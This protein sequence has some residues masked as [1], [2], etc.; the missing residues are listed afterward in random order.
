[1]TVHTGMV[2][3]V[4][5]CLI[6]PVLYT[7]GPS[8]IAYYTKFGFYYI[9]LTVSASLMIPFAVLR[10]KDTRN[11]LWSNLFMRGTAKL[12]G[13]DWQIVNEFEVFRN[14]IYIKCRSPYSLPLSTLQRESPKRYIIQL[15]KGH[16]IV[17]RLKGGWQPL[18]ELQSL[19]ST[20]KA[21]LT[22]WPCLQSFIP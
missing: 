13:L 21:V 1:M 19:Y 10:P 14:L 8:W 12:L 20:T 2:V 11:L 4:A 5:S 9:S 3:G 6:F 22:F 17:S 18:L 7:R 15:K 16:S